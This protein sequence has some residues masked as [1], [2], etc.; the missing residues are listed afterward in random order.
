MHL[1]GANFAW[2][3]DYA[4]IYLVDVSAPVIPGLEDL[5]PDVFAARH[6]IAPAGMVV[7]TA[8][9][10]RQELRIAIHDSYPEPSTADALSDTPFTQVL[11]TRVRFPSCHF[12]I[13]SP[14]RSGGEEWGPRFTVPHDRVDVRISWC[15]VD[16]DRYNAHRPFADVIQVELWPSA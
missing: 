6:F 11:E 9:C 16:D 3:S 2:V 7:Y 5:G 13:G 4:Q 1:G 12:T 8:D 14:S 15:E 10:L